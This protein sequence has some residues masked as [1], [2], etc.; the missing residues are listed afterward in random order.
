MC[1]LF[2][3]PGHFLSKVDF[4]FG[5][6]LRPNYALH[7]RHDQPPFGSGIKIISP[8]INDCLAP[9]FKA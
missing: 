1:N 9:I 8:P 6:V 3:D 7:S 2:D 4:G 5:V